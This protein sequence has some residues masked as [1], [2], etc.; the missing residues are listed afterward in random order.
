VEAELVDAIAQ[1]YGMSPLDVLASD[2]A[3]LRI[4]RL[5]TLE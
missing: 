2:T 4:F 3:L 5:V 1:R